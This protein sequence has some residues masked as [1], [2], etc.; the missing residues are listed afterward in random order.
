M[1]AALMFDKILAFVES[2]RAVFAYESARVFVQFH[3][4]SF[5]VCAEL[6]TAYFAA[7]FVFHFRMR[8]LMSFELTS[9][10]EAFLATG[11]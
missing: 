1:F 8:C 6:F 4:T 11:T 5:I 9:I 10:W 2:L 3:M 7:D